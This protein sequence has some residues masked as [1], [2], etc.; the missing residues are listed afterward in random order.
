MLIRTLLLTLPDQPGSLGRVTTLM[1]RLGIDIQQVRVLSRDGTT[2]TDEFVV[3]VPGPVIEGR[4]VAVLEEVDGVRVLYNDPPG[5]P[6][7]A[8]AG[9]P[10]RAPAGAPQR[11]PAG[12]PHHGPAGAPQPA[13]RITGPPA[14]PTTPQAR[15]IATSQCP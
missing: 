11:A 2:A 13:P 5:A 3:A 12:A 14:Q 9:A 4:L 7:R 8:P 1:G 15:R 6:Q 10:Q